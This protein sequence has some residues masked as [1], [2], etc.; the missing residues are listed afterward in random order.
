MFHAFNECPLFVA[1][2]VGVVL[3]GFVFVGFVFVGVIVDFSSMPHVGLTILGLADET[4]RPIIS[5]L[6][7]TSHRLNRLSEVK[8][9]SEKIFICK[10]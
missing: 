4:S 9:L 1:R 7:R 6:L 2:V 3:V 8:T 10:D 5:W